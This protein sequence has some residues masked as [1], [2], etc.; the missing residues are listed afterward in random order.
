[1]KK[2]LGFQFTDRVGNNIAGDNNDPA[3]GPSYLILRPNLA[4][5][6]AAENPGFLLMPIFEG[7]IESPDF[8]DIL[9]ITELDNLIRIMRS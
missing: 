5:K 1:M 2:F 4:F 7:D 6:L 9:D 3:K 8:S